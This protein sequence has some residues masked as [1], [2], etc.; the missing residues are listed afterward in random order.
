M[1]AAKGDGGK[2]LEVARDY[3]ILNVSTETILCSTFL[4][5]NFYFA[6]NC[7]IFKPKLY[8][9]IVLCRIVLCYII[10]SYTTWHHAL[11]TKY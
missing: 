6:F 2:A 7:N 11:T 4:I 3:R 10:L 1:C 5:Q 8:Y 9:N